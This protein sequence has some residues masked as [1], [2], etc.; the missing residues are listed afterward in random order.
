MMYETVAVNGHLEVPPQH[1]AAVTAVIGANVKS[2]RV[3]EGDFVKRGSV[4]GT[5]AHPELIQIQT[6][7]VKKYNAFLFLKKEYER[8][9][10]LLKNDIASQKS[11]QATQRDFRSAKGVCEGLR[12]QLLQ[13][14]L[15]PKAVREG[16]ISSTAP[17]ISPISGFVED[18]NIKIGQYITPSQPLFTLVNIEHL[19]ADFMVY[20]KDV[21]KI[22]KGQQIRVRIPSIPSYSGEATIRSVGNKFE[23]SPRALHI[24]AEFDKKEDFMIPGLYITGNIQVGEEKSTALPSTAIVSEGEKSYIFTAKKQA[25][26]WH[27]QPVAITTGKTDGDWVTVHLPTNF[28]TT[29]QVAW[30][31]AYKLIS[32]M[33]KSATSHSH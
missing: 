26:E 9:K 3:I 13:L 6:E 25:N 8:Q 29:Q 12:M 24:H 18:I 32:E 1:E 5:L 31:A 17:I 23:D 21:S 30:T 20:E 14:H 2:I 10:T 4:L 16:N 7:Y 11:F 27:F 22:H 19:H 33:K 15:N 28:D